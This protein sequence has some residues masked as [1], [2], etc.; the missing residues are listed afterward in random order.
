M[1]RITKRWLRILPDWRLQVHAWVSETA[2]YLWAEQELERHFPDHL[3]DTEPLRTPF[4]SHLAYSGSRLRR[5]VTSAAC[6]V[7]KIKLK[8]CVLRNLGDFTRDILPLSCSRTSHSQ[9]FINPAACEQLLCSLH[10]SHPL[11][12][13]AWHQPRTTQL[14]K[15]LIWPSS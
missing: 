13:E 9:T 5:L 2:T 4:L 11:R 15:T 12:Y 8:S 6:L 7:F 3:L 14:Q 1:V 10:R